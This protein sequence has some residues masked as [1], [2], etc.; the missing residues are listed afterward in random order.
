[1]KNNY[2]A[3]VPIDEH[4]YQTVNQEMILFAQEKL[5]DNYYN[6][7]NHSR[8]KHSHFLE[9]YGDEFFAECPLLK[10]WLDSQKL[11]LHLS[12]LI[13]ATEIHAHIDYTSEWHDTYKLPNGEF[14][15]LVLLWPIHNYENS[16]GFHY[17]FKDDYDGYVILG[18][19]KTHVYRYSDLV[20]ITD[21]SYKFK[22]NH[23]IVIRADV[24]HAVKHYDTKPRIV[25]A[26]RFKED[27]WHLM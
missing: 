1:M 23:L 4:V 8:S 21:A 20:Q 17:R 27:P 25:A 14:P 16:E 9:V 13:A 26:L 22:P 12:T 18:K 7:S 3:Y 24:P 11:E 6:L 15:K 5:G 10:E 19:S 2:Y